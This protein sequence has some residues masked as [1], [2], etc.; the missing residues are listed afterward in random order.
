MLK[1]CNMLNISTN[2]S[3]I[4]LGY[5]EGTKHSWDLTNLTKFQYF[6][7]LK[8]EWTQAFRWH[9]GIWK[10]DD[11]QVTSPGEKTSQGPFQSVVYQLHAVL[12]GPSWGLL[13]LAKIHYRVWDKEYCFWDCAQVEQNT[14]IIS[15][16]D[17]YPDLWKQTRFICR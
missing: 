13:P 16:Y 3:W 4:V 5:L 14:W 2:I 11:K 10:I 6:K 9:D 17:D 8:L 7:T 1:F 12:Q 15:K